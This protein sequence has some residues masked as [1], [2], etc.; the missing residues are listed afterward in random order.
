MEV[1]FVRRRLITAIERARRGSQERRQRA[2]DTERSYDAF[3]QQVA[4]PVV[5]MLATTLKAEGYPFTV[6]TPAGRV[7]L[8]SDK[9][10]DDY[11]ELMLDAAIDPPQVVGL[12]SYGRGSRTVSDERP[13]KA[14]AAPEAI[15]EEDVLEFFVKSLEPWLER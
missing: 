12:V 9:G 4:I 5:R 8:A 1:S 10:R 3:L 15:T 11:I 13:V 6:F 2:A 14:D 7:R